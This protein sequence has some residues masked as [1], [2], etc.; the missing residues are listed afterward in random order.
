MLPLVP[1][2][3]ELASL[4]AHKASLCLYLSAR[5]VEAAQTKLMAHYSADTPVAIC[6]RLGLPMKGF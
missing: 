2:T 5:M 3:E 6:F 1:E 4:A